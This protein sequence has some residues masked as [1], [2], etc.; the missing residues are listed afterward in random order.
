L[1]NKFSAGIGVDG[2]FGPGTETAV[3]VIIS[4]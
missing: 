3:K 2:Q 4:E 1:R